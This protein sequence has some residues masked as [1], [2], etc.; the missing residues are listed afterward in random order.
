VSASNKWNETSPLVMTRGDVLRGE[1]LTPASVGGRGLT[2]GSV[3]YWDDQSTK[4]HRSLSPATYHA[5]WQC[6]K[7]FS[8]HEIRTSQARPHGAVHTHP[9]YAL[10]C[11]SL[12]S[13]CKCCVHWCDPDAELKHRLKAAAT[14]GVAHCS[15]SLLGATAALSCRGL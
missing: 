12:S 7:L 1:T 5:R 10:S 14:A 2:P 4:V 3:R 13:P 11:L 15:L 8:F 6:R 9:P